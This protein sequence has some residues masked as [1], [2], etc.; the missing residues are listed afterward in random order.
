MKLPLIDSDELRATANE[1]AGLLKVGLVGTGEA[2]QAEVLFEFCQLLHLEAQTR[3]ANVEVDLRELE[4]LNSSC[5]KAFVTGFAQVQ[6]L[7]A[8]DQYS[9][10]LISNPRKHWQKRS[11]GAL[12]SFAPGLITIT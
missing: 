10:H 4:F 6:E 11:L 12:E 2:G 8:T 7:D 5:F 1:S 3:K 9:I